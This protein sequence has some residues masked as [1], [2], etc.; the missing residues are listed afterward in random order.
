MVSPKAVA[1]SMQRTPSRTRRTIVSVNIGRAERISF[2]GRDHLT[3]ICK[4]PVAGPVAVHRAGIGDDVVCNQKHHG[5]PDQAVYIYGAED[6]A[7]WERELGCRLA[8]GA[9]G[10]NL[11]VNGL[12]GNLAVG[13]R[14]L[15]GSTVL[16]LTAP[17]IPC[18]V[19]S[20]RMQD[21]NFVRAFRE[22]AR[23]GAYCRVLNPG[24]V[25][26]G[27][28]VEWVAAVGPAAGVLELFE[29]ANGARATPT[30]VERFLAAP[31]SARLRRKVEASRRR[32]GR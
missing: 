26:A 4:H 30:D 7:W 20:A 27:D 3:G 13:D 28:P 16:E 24:E 17:R 1:V 2:L 9:F 21:R 31:L 6:Y 22:A 8:P 23:P 29:F 18:A 5:G 15:I 19:L 12:P 32:A 25:R 11:T 10:E 14:L